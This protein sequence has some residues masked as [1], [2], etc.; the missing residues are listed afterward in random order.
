MTAELAAWI[1]V[2]VLGVLLAVLGIIEAGRDLD[3]LRQLPRNGRW[4]VARHQLIRYHLR[5]G[6]WATSILAMF[7]LGAPDLIAW[8]LILDRVLLV[9]I[10]SSD[11]V[12]G[13]FLRRG[14]AQELQ[15][16]DEQ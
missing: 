1:G 9:A 3:A 11:L 2:V 14:I 16:E 7:A 4:M 15:R 12:T 6:M 10:T 8:L 13:A 5:L